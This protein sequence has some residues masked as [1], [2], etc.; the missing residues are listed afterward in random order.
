VL[1]FSSSIAFIIGTIVI[2]QQINYARN[3]P[4][5][6]DPSRLIVTEGVNGS[7]TAIKEA[8][9][10]S[11]MVANMTVSFSPPTEIYEYGDVERWTGGTPTNVPVKVALNAIGDTDYFRTLGM[12]LQRRPEFRG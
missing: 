8:A 7:Y 11:G 6:Y 12:A 5:G 2:Y 4:R 10:Q 9:L 3:R 1:Q